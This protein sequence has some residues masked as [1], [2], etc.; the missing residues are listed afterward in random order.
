MEQGIKYKIA[1]IFR[2]I[3]IGKDK[4]MNRFTQPM[5][6]AITVSTWIKVY[7]P[8]MRIIQGLG[9]IIFLAL[10]FGLTYIITGFLWQK[11]KLLT[12]EYRFDNLRSP[13][14]MEIDKRLKKIEEVINKLKNKLI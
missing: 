1:S 13:V 4:V 2:C 12:E 5:L 8:D 11:S 3:D 7:F 6:F 9:F 10:M 14:L